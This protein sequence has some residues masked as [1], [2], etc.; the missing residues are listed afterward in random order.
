MIHDNRHL[1][2]LY[3]NDHRIEE[4]E[5]PEDPDWLALKAIYERRD[6]VLKELVE[7]ERALATKRFEAMDPSDYY[8]NGGRVVFYNP[9]T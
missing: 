1:Y 9:P 2:Y 6:A 5:S 4:F 8:V 7:A 3:F